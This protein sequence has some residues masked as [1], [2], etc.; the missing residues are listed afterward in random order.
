MYN[1]GKYVNPGEVAGIGLIMAKSAKKH[2]T[3]FRRSPGAPGAGRPEVKM[4]FAACAGEAAQS[5]AAAG[6]PSRLCR[7]SKVATCMEGKGL[8]TGVCYRRSKSK[9]APFAGRK[10]KIACGG[11]V[12]V[13]NKTAILV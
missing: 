2:L 1:L 3:V 8:S 10:Y 7:T 11:T 12:G 13:G 5:C 9:F 4:A 6:D